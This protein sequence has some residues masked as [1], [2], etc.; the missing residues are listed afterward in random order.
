MAKRSKSFIDGMKHAIK[1]AAETE[2]AARRVGE[3]IPAEYVN[4]AIRR[5]IEDIRKNESN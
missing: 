1:I 3:T 2:D 4:K 5:I